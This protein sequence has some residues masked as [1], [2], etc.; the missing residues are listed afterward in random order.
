FDTDTRSFGKPDLLKHFRE[1]FF[2]S[3]EEFLCSFS[4]FL[5]LDTSIDVFCVFTED[6]HVCFLRFFYRRRNAFEP[7]NRTKASIEVEILAKGNIERTNATA[8][9]C[10]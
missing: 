10:C 5:E 4:S 9:R 3:T 6:N 1:C 8:H 7:A 2:K